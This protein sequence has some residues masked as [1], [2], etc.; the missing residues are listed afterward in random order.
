MKNA[1]FI[2]ELMATAMGGPLGPVELPRRLLR[3]ASSRTSRIRCRA[4]IPPGRPGRECKPC[5]ER[6]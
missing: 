6:K 2:I 5:R 1:A 4:P 3:L